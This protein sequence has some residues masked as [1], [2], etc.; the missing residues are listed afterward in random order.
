LPTPTAPDFD[1]L[2]HGISQSGGTPAKLARILDTL[3]ADQ[4]AKVETA[5]RNPDISAARIAKALSKLGPQYA[6]A[7]GSVTTWR[8]HN[9]IA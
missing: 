9:G 5:L 1:A 3:P 6:C 4:R 2:L 8:R 7:D